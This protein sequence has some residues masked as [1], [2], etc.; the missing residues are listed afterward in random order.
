MAGRQSAAV[1]E[2]VVELYER[3]WTAPAADHERIRAG[4]RSSMNDR[5]A[6]AHLADRQQPQLAV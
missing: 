4:N 1:M 6:I 3:R 5:D 2:A